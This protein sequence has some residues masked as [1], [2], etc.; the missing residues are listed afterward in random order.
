[1]FRTLRHARL[2][3]I[4]ACVTVCLL[5]P[6]SAVA[7]GGQPDVKQQSSSAITMGSI[8]EQLG[9]KVV[10]KNIELGIGQSLTGTVTDAAKLAKFGITGIHEGAR[11]TAF[12]SAPDKLRIEVDEL[13]PAPVNKK[14]TL[15]LDD[16]GRLSA[17]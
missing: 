15:K 14:A 16:R 1:M 5:I 9:A 2:R 7:Q 4:A 12:R 10:D 13:E 8:A 17:P 11:L 6:P 3:A